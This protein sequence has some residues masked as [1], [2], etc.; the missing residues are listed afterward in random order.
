MSESS[1]REP[2]IAFRNVTKTFQ[3]PDGTTVRAVSDFSVDIARGETVAL[4]GESGSGKTTVGKL[5]LGLLAPDTGE[6]AFE[7]ASMAEAHESDRRRMRAKL[8]V[9]FQEPYESLNPRRKIAATVEEPLL[10]HRV[11]DRASRQ[12]RVSEVLDL[13]GL[14]KDVAGRYPGELSGGQQQRVGIARAIV[15]EPSLIVL[16]EP[17]ASLDRTIRAQVTDLLKGLQRDLGLSYLLI[18]HDIGSVR[19]MADRAIVMFRGEQVEVGTMVDVISRPAHPYT[20]AL[21]S[22]ELKAVPG[23][24]GER[25]KLMP[26]AAGAPAPEIGC[27]LA[28]VCP[29]AIDMCRS[30]HPPLLDVTADHVSAC[31]RWQD[32][33]GSSS[34]GQPQPSPAVHAQGNAR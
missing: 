14:P 29:L 27:P 17:T 2:V 1:P 3:A 30:E 26:R 33:L 13:V 18:T 28:P 10:V 31:F 32:L 24:V 25:F 20:K 6:V 9:V 11:G 19:R 22:S 12:K 5:M 21:V 23:S 34:T 7:G 4:I 8:Q 15:G 16:D